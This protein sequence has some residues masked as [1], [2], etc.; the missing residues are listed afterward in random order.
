M[1]VGVRGRLTRRAL[2]SLF[3]P[4]HRALGLGLGGGFFSRKISVIKGALIVGSGCLLGAALFFAAP[5]FREAV[6]VALSPWK[7]L[8]SLDPKAG[9]LHLQALAHQAEQN[10]DAEGLAFCATRTR[11]SG[12]S[13]RLAEEA[14]GLNPDLLWIYAAVAVRHPELPEIRAWIPKLETWNPQNALFPLIV[15]GSHDVQHPFG[16]EG[17][18]EGHEKG[19]AWRGA[20]SAAFASNRFDDYFDRMKELDRIVVLRYR[21]YEPE[22]VLFDEGTGIPVSGLQDSR[23]FATSLI[24]SGKNLEV[25]GHPKLASEKYWTVAR[26]GQLIASQDHTQVEQWTSHGLQAMAYK[27]LQEVSQKKGNRNEADLFGY[28]AAKFDPAKELNTMRRDRV[29]TQYIC[30]RN[31]AFLQIAAVLGVV[32]IGLVLAAILISIFRRGPGGDAGARRTKAR[33]AMLGFT[34]AA[35]LL[36]STATIYLTFRPY[37]YIFQSAVLTGDRSH[38][39]DLADFLVAAQMLPSL[40]QNREW[41]LHLPFYFWAAVI[42]S[43][44]AGLGF[45]L[46]RHLRTS[47][48]AKDLPQNPQVP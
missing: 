15:A 45:I 12:E 10:H 39:A 4:G 14:V 18:T 32:F 29:F 17:A 16:N 7:Q 33:A 1:G 35:G 8:L 13:A 36:L 31:A 19:P 3:F 37:W 46:L 47:T 30:R 41:L 24:Q 21:F 27:Q 42:L 2:T 11:D 38:V 43:G 20:M 28:L 22:E 48:P 26:F 25:Q 6:Q 34:G 23:L 44:I 9:Q 40:G 5:P